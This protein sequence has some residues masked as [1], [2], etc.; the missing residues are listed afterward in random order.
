MP[1]TRKRVVV[2]Y[3]DPLHVGHIRRL[4]EICSPGERIVVVIADPP[5]PILSTRARAE[6]VSALD[7]VEF[8]V[9]AG[10]AADQAVEPFADV[11]DER[12]ADMARTR[13]FAQ[14]VFARYSME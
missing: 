10:E 1:P 14:H 12:E 11:V 9:P 4:R 7:F 13:S 2:G 8:V 3:F 6:L 5:A